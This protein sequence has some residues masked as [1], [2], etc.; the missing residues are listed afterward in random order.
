MLIQRGQLYFPGAT[1]FR[2]F[3]NYQPRRAAK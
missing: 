1:L 3:I 2:V